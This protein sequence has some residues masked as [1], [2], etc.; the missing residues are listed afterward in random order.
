M[1]LVSAWP[2][3]GT[4]PFE[5]KPGDYKIGR[6]SEHAVTIYDSSISRIHARLRVSE[7]GE[8]TIE[9]LGSRNG[10]EVNGKLAQFAVLRLND[11][12]RLGAVPCLVTPERQ[13]R[14]FSPDDDES[15]MRGTLENGGVRLRVDAKLSQPQV[16]VL[17][18]IAE[19]LTEDEVANKTGRSYHTVHNHVR[20]IYK[21]YDVHSRG[22]LLSRLKNGPAQAK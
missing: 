20:V 14:S 6:S 9:D 21:V 4:L 5:L 18:L 12:L 11:R 7:R 22:E 15:T 3:A 16:E 8:V 1:W 19:G 10:V 17:R 13:L 2:V